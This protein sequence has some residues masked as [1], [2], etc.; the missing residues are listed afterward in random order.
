MPA[1]THTAQQRLDNYLCSIV[2]SLVM[3]QLEVSRSQHT[4]EVAIR[5]YHVTEPIVCIVAK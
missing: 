2:L 3:V 5:L 4:F 1:H